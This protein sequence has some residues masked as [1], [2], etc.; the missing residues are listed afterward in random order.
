ME[1]RKV[2]QSR[3][4][5]VGATVIFGTVGL[6][7]QNLSLSSGVVSVYRGVFGSLFLLLVLLL[8]RKRLRFAEL[9]N[10]L[11]L[12][13]CSGAALGLNWI[14][15][16]ESYRFTTIATA[17]LCYYMAPFYVIL[18][19]VPLFRERLTLRRGLCCA[20]AFFGVVCVSGV[21]ETALSWKD[22]RGVVFGLAA[23]VFYATLTLLN[24]KIGAAPPYEKTMIQMLTAA[25][26][27]LPYVLIGKQSFALSN[28]TDLWLV[29]VLCVLH[30]GT[31]FALF[32]DAIGHLPAQTTAL[33]SFIDPAVAV[34]LS[35]VV[36]QR[37]T[38]TET[39]GTVL[40]LGAAVCNEK[41]A[42]PTKRGK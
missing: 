18:A 20:V 29:I 3:L 8:R 22:F 34:V 6:F 13:L 42:I 28:A 14:F 33:M 39:V 23:G 11:P 35:A 15:L 27:L 2:W 7:R 19:S 36:Q 1:Q 12:L 5:L 16:F 30:S 41:I 25:A 31:A 26:I 38:W 10:R 9:K 37:P 21:M 4:E 32:F 40:I 24:K 17:T